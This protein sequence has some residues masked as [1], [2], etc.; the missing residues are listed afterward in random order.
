MHFLWSRVSNY[1]LLFHW[2]R[3]HHFRALELLIRNLITFTLLKY[4]TRVFA[5]TFL[6]CWTT[7]LWSNRNLT[8]LDSLIRSLIRHCK[9]IINSLILF[10]IPAVHFS[11]PSELIIDPLL[12]MV[13]L[14]L[15]IVLL[16]LYGLEA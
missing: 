9:Y 6:Y 10:P 11:L 3:L 7:S 4:W 12:S 2:R 14:L 13:E 16:V 15:N 1:M 5:I 8:L